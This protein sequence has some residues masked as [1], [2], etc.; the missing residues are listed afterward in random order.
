[1]LY[2]REAGL[3]AC[4]SVSLIRVWFSRG[5]SRPVPGRHKRAPL[6]S[7]SAFADHNSLTAF[8]TT[9]HAVLDRSY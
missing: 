5:M 8:L 1:M 7:L 2:A 9:G 3:L 4:R 6:T